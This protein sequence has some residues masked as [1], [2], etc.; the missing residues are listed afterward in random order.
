MRKYIETVIGECDLCNRSKSNRYVP[1]GLLQSPAT[2]RQAWNSIAFD[3]IV[4]LPLSK[5]LM[6]KVIYDSIWVVTDRVT[7]Y[8]HFVPYKE[9]SDAKELVYVFMKV[10]VNQYGLP[11]EII[12]DRDKFFT[13]KFWTSL[14]AQLGAHHKL[15]TAFYPQTDGQTERLNQSLEQYLRSYVNY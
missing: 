12:S 4:K 1:Y 7:K 10:V 5:E 15:S 11:D 13:S 9:S 14:L 6:T 3:F 2:P 8:R